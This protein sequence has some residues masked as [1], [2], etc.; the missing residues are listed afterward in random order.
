[1]A[2]Q[3]NEEGVTLEPLEHEAPPSWPSGS[4]AATS[5]CFVTDVPDGAPRHFATHPTHGLAESRKGI[6][7][8]D[9]LSRVAG[10]NHIPNGNG[11]VEGNDTVL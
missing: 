1:M 6:A 9:V 8:T 11:T 10:E 2:M 4:M 5:I 7:L 3:A